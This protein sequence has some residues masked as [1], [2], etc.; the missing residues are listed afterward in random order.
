MPWQVRYEGHLT[1][2]G[3][4]YEF[5]SLVEEFLGNFDESLGIKSLE[6]I[7]GWNEE[8]AQNALPPCEF[9]RE[10]MGPASSA[11]KLQRIQLKRS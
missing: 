5:P 4:D 9:V 2:V 1:F 8:N 11:N 3:T 10:T 6:D 7:I